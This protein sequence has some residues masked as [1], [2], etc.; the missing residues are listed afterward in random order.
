MLNLL[1]RRCRAA[2]ARVFLPALICLLPA[3]T[4]AQDLGLREAPAAAR[5]VR[6]VIVRFNGA[7]TLDEARVRSQMATRPGQPYLDE[8]V[9]RDI[10]SL[11]GTGAI[12]NLDI[13]AQNVGEYLAHES[14]D[15]VPRAEASAYLQGVDALRE[16]VDR[17]AA[18]VNAL[19]S[20]NRS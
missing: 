4:N 14:G 11:Y 17:V 16:Q 6:D 3:L 20:E 9:E 7:A 8:T 10:R 12:E 5:I 1:S 2:L 18:R 13:Q 15:L 19:E